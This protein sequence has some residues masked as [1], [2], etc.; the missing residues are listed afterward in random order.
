[1]ESLQAVELL[2]NRLPIEADLQAFLTASREA[3]V[4]LGG[5]EME[6]AEALLKLS[7]MLRRAGAGS[8]QP[9]A[10]SLVLRD[11]GLVAEWDQGDERGALTLGRLPE[12]PT[13][14]AAERLRRRL[15]AEYRIHD[16]EALLHRNREMVNRFESSRG[17]MV[18]E[19]EALQQALER[20]Q[21]ELQES[22]RE[23]ETDPLT[24]IYNRRAFDERIAQAFQR[25]MRQ[26]TEGLSLL[27]V[28][29][30]HFKEVNDTY[31]HGYGD[32]YLRRTA[33]ALVSVIRKDV[34]AAFRIG[35]D[36]FAV[37][38]FAGGEA[39]CG[40][41]MQVVEAMESRVSIGIAAIAP[42]QAYPGT[43]ETFIQEADA[44]LY[45]AKQLGR[46]RVVRA[47][48]RGRPPVGCV[49]ACSAATAGG[50]TA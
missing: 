21:R 39:A 7:R 41:A 33:Q 38:L 48:C 49:E 15:I 28:D 19:L 26:G 11:S 50:A 24:Q 42:G 2:E 36:E 8:G 43:V 23:A 37:L 4:E 44:A 20:R 9:V 16:P 47:Q 5:G 18:R 30:D 13:E 12:P 46:G 14:A 6:S 35:G 32:N 25:T 40:K 3:V 31:G 27:L 29:L 17:R 10:A 22:I 34:D 45:E 1:M